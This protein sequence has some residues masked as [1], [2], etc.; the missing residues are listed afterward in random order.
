MGRDQGG[1]AGRPDDRVKRLE[2]MDR[3]FR[4]EI[5]GRSPASNMLGPLATARAI[6]TRYCSP[7]DNSK[8]GVRRARIGRGNVAIARRGP[9]QRL[10]HTGRVSGMSIICQP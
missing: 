5:A 7:P 3:G 9:N 4:I 1:T 8:A 2:N 10:N 6:A